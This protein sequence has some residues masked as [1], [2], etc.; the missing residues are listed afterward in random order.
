MKDQKMQSKEFHP[1][2][3]AHEL[4]SRLNNGE[5][6]LTIIDIRS[7]EDFRQRRILG[8]I[9]M[10]M[11][12]LMQSSEFSFDYNRDIY[13]YGASEEDTATA[14]NYLRQAGFG[15]VA[16]LKGG[17]DAFQE[18]GGSVEGIA[19]NEDAPS[20]D[21]YNVVSRLNQFAKEKAIEKSMS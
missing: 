17:I 19:T 13:V 18:I 20:P 16:E 10:P 8:A 3:T 11:E 14:A 5:P 1:Q 2:A 6:A 9:T 7:P 15:R 4:K 21:N 12:N